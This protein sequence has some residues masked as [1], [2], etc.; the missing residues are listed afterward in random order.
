VV[1]CG[2]VSLALSEPKASSEA[3]EAT[4]GSNR[5]GAMMFARAPICLVDGVASGFS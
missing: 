5:R 2:S 3:M 4:E 1:E